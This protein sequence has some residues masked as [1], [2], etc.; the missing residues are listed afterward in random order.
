MPGPGH[1]CG[2]PTKKSIAA[3]DEYYFEQAMD[4]AVKSWGDESY[5]QVRAGEPDDPDKKLKAA[6][7]SVMA[8]PQCGCT[9]FHRAG[10][11]YSQE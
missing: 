11:P 7:C 6:V 1:P 3:R 4:R 10:C 9:V 8:I 5:R 2:G